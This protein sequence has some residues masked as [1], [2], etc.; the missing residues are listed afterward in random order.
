M[1]IVQSWYLGSEAGNAIASV[2]NG[3]VNPS[4]KLPF[5]FPKK[6]SDNAAHFYGKLSYPGN[7]ETQ[8]YKED[9]LVG[10]RWHDTKSIKP[11]FAFG[12]G[13]TYTSFKLSNII[14]DKKT[15]NSVGTIK[16]SCKVKNT[17]D[18]TGKE[19]IQV[20]VG[21]KT[22]KVKRAL[23]EL[24]G[25][26]KI[27]VLKGGFEKIEIKIAINKLA[28]Y[29][30]KISDWNVEKGDYIIYVGNSSDNISKQIPITI[31]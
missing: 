19:V 10:Y 22:S 12:Y 25:F 18:F 15:Y 27:S 28:F 3:E 14:S 31:I 20:Y 7:G 17:G 8:Y 1:S 11:E 2:L 23:K 26:K 5:S 9:I 4:G 29:D 21:K 6:L 24:K 30:E 16:I 13:M